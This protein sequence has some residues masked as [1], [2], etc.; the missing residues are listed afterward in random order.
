MKERKVS[1]LNEYN[2][3]LIGIKTIPS[4]KKEKHPTVLLVHGFG[5][6]KEEGGMFDELTKNLVDAEFLVYRFDF[7]GRGESEGDYSETSLTKQ[8]SDLLKIVEFVKSQK[9]VDVSRI[10]ILAQSFGTAVTVALK[11]KVKTVILM[12]SVAHPQLVLGEP[13]KWEILDKN[14]TSKKVKSNGEIIFIK[15]QFWK[16]MDNYDLLKSISKIN[17]PILFIHG[18][19]DDRMPLSEMESYF[20][21]ANEP[22]EKIIIEGADHGLRPH[23]TKMYKIAVDW[24][25]KHLV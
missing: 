5:V 7:S 12:G 11:P 16:D 4:I 25:K 14:G 9:K 21:N 23:R 6:T 1:T 18:S 19:L 10:G 22:K 13:F 2:E 15:S 17:C 24:F 3:K 20:K 8:K